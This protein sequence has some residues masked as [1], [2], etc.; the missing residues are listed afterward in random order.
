MREN[1]QFLCFKGGG[2]SLVLFYVVCA[3]RGVGVPVEE[4]G[5]NIS[6]ERVNKSPERSCSRIKGLL[7]CV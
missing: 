4:R 2:D 7:V 1:S 5:P 3:I 6:Y